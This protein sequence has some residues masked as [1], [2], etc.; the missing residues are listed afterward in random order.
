MKIRGIHH[1]ELTVKDLNASKSFYSLLP[2]FKI[3][4]EY[5][6]F[7]M[8][9]NNHLN[10]GLTTHKNI[11]LIPKFDEKNIG[12]DHFALELGSEKELKEA[13]DLL[14]KN[15]IVHSNIQNLSNGTKLIVFRDPDNIQL[16]FCYRKA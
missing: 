6:D 9:S 12:L 13:L 8:F 14:V 1:I 2:G 15:S 10:I 4:A 7:V 11:N 5:E 16:E 3:V